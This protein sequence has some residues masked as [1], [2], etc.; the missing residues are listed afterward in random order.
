MNKQY[1][2]IFTMALLMMVSMG[3]W[4][5]QTIRVEKS[6]N[7][8]VAVSV[9]T[10]L[11]LTTTKTTDE[12]TDYSLSG[13]PEGKHATVTLTTTPA[14]GYYTLLPVVQKTYSIPSPSPT[15]SP[16]ISTITVSSPDAN[17]YTFEMPD[18][19]Y[20]VKITVEFA[21]AA[22]RYFTLH[23]DGK[24]YMRQWKGIVNN[25]GT[26]HYENAYDGNGSSIWVYSNDGYLQN[27]MY[28][29][30]VINGKTLYLSP[31]PVT[32]WNLVD[33]GDKKRF[34]MNGS[35]KILG[36]NSSNA[37]VLEETP[38]FDYAACTLTVTE[39]NSKWDGPKDLDVTVQS[40]QLLTYLH[41]L[42]SQHHCYY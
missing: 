32:K 2:R 20:G 6:A 23:K 37:V 1:M 28:Y 24:G 36:L 8:S 39:N 26:F 7:G 42:Y 4:A 31:T 40:P 5:D 10:G 19:D 22:Y 12:Y 35:T 18:A 15:R 3:A 34:Q 17:T 16:G 33:D 30:N 29:L 11:T 14:V 38:A 41:L 21:N 27:E 9:S 25:D 13:V